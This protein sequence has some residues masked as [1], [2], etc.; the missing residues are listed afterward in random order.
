MP[1]TIHIPNKPRMPKTTLFTEKLKENDMY[2]SRAQV[3]K[4]YGYLPPSVTRIILASKTK[5]EQTALKKMLRDPNSEMAKATARGRNFHRAVETGEAVDAHTEKVL[6]V[7]RKDILSDI[8]EVWAQ[9]KSIIH[10][11]HKY[12]GKFDGVGIYKGKLTLF[13][14]KKT[15]KPK[16]TNSSMRNYLIQLCAY[17]KAHDAMYQD[18]KIE[19]VAI[20]NLYGKNVDDI[21]SNIKILNEA[22]IED[23]TER[24]YS[25]LLKYYMEMHGALWG[26]QTD[27]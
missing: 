11:E 20:F 27:H 22:E 18:H 14:Y 6:E 25:H 17:K 9:E 5:R 24:F 13:D 21:G 19:Q 12:C 26:L 16:K 7:F 15:N 23:H 4:K 1:Y 2:L 10:D 8:D 3:N